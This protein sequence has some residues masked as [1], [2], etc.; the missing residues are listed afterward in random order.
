M[1]LKRVKLNNLGDSFFLKN[2]RA[3][4][5][6]FIILGILL[7]AMVSLVFIFRD[8]L[9]PNK[10]GINTDPVY[11]TFINCLEEDLRIGANVLGSQGGYIYLPEYEQGSKYS[12]FSSQLDFL[13]NPIPYWYYVSGNNIQKERVPSKRDME[14]ELSKFISSKLKTCFFDNY[15]SQGYS[16][17]M[18]E[19]D[20]HIRISENN[21][22]LDLDMDFSISRGDKNLVAR[23]HKVTIDSQLGSLYD[24][25]LKI[26]KH[27]SDE[28]FLEKYAIDVLRLYA[29]VD[30]VELSCTPITWDASQ[31]FSELREAIQFNTMSIKNGNAPGKY[32]EV[33]IRGVPSNHNVRFLNSQNWTSMY[34]V[35]PS[36]GQLMVAS[37]VGDQ[38]GMGIVGFCYVA[39][40]FVYSMKY[41]VLVQISS[42]DNAE[43]IFQF[44][45]AIV[46]ERNT[47]RGAPAGES[48]E[49]QPYEELCSEMNTMIRV[50][51]YDTNLKPI[52]AFVSYSCLGAT[53]NI[54]TTQE[55]SLL[56]NF[57]QCVNGFIN[58]QADG[59]KEENIMYSTVSPGA[60]SVYLSKYYDLDI[61][62]R[63]DGN[64]YNGESLIYFTS[65][66]DFKIIFYPQQK[67]VRLGE[68]EY[69][70]Q[71]HIYKDPN[72]NVGST[73][74]KKC[75][76]APLAFLGG[77][78]KLTRKKC[79]DVE[80]PAQTI[81]N[82]L[83]GGGKLNYSFLEEDLKRARAL[84]INAE[85]FP[86]PNTLEQIQ[87]NYILF[88]ESKLEARLI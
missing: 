44:P 31:V 18:G 9:F 2:K 23:K 27:E 13:G 42:N 48:L 86:T 15:Y 64:L 20:A 58:V 37:P 47:P 21:I 49:P 17:L 55:G 63:M 62:L 59:Y 61:Q 4:L 36:E 35:N 87:K 80:V 73:T 78:L 7:V 40:H 43:E 41:P 60:V 25:A 5:A 46:I 84:E 75:I 14:D 11:R 54:G 79:Y 57:P 29:P 39:Y 67:T 50:D 70:I 66:D 12:P 53:C 33:D 32:F 74:Q 1:G 6:I 24:S 19:P 8:S 3:Q 51:V 45:L 22:I 34:E 82:A 38:K 56:R 65:G 85:N 71:V 52:D 16:I 72:L 10:S 77:A 88:E 69:E 68:G 81:S 28:L 83:A 30:G 76:D 26:Y